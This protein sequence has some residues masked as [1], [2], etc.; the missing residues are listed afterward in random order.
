MARKA[1]R[2][3]AASKSTKSPAAKRRKSSAA[4]RVSGAK[5][6]NRSSSAKKVKT[7]SVEAFLRFTRTLHDRGLVTQLARSATK[8]NLSLAMD[9][10]A[11]A[12][13]KRSVNSAAEAKPR[14]RPKP[15]PAAAS[16]F[17]TA[18]PTAGGDPW[19]FG[20]GNGPSGGLGGVKPLPPG[21][22]PW[23]F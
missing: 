18:A 21:Q 14:A 23:D 1:K 16:A 19:D 2:G 10:A 22:D 9:A 6:A 8:E 17:A 15:S 7:V 4:K 3:A 11:L 5:R 12:R 13:V 20:S